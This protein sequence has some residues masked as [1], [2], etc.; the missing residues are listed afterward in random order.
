M[1]IFLLLN[2]YPMNDRAAALIYQG[3]RGRLH[4]HRLRPDPARAR[5]PA[6]DR[7]AGRRAP[8]VTEYYLITG[9]DCSLIK[10][11]A[12]AI[13]Q[14]EAILDRF[15]AY[16][17]TTTSIVVSAPLPRRPPRPAPDGAS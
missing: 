16:G 1:R 9:E 5:Q 15:L 17:N 12:P 13:E 4:G 8:Q 7:R 11:Q 2:H 3:G 14:L 10:L 6:Q